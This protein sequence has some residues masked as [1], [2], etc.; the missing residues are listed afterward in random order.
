[1]QIRKSLLALLL[2]GSA[3]YTVAT[4]ATE[5]LS[6]LL[7]EETDSKPQ[8][9]KPVIK[10]SAEETHSAPPQVLGDGTR[11]VA[12]DGTEVTEVE[13]ALQPVQ[14]EQQSTPHDVQ[15]KLDADISP[16]LG[17]GA[18]K[19][20]ML[21]LLGVVLLVTGV[22]LSLAGNKKSKVMRT[23]QTSFETTLQQS[24]ELMDKLGVKSA[25]K[26]AFGCILAGLIELAR[27]LRANQNGQTGNKAPTLKGRLTL[28]FGALALLVTMSGAGVDLSSLNVGELFK[29]LGE[30]I[31]KTHLGLF[32]TG[33]T[34]LVKSIYDIVAYQQQQN[35]LQQAGS[36]TAARESEVRGT[37]DKSQ[38]AAPADE[39]VNAESTAPGEKNTAGQANAA[40]VLKEEAT[41]EEA[42]TG[43]PEAQEENPAT[44]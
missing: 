7:V 42:P 16:L 25:S 24:V 3:A 27:S 17:S 9:G 30:Y 20:R 4:P 40:N 26:M 33:G 12:A 21:V 18:C 35:Q 10:A 2:V 1:M 38:T 31:S 44:R 23:A 14:T 15:K 32:A 6:P 11:A 39:T 43:T 13:A 41:G 19:G 36:D 29:V 22:S 8:T 34:T 5:D 37:V 28:F